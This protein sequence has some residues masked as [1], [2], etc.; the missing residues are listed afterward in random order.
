MTSKKGVEL[1]PTNMWS[2]HFVG[3]VYFFQG[4]YEKA[5]GMFESVN[6]KLKP[7]FRISLVAQTHFYLGQIEGAVNMLE[8]GLKEYPDEPQLNST[9]AI[10]LASKG[11][12]GE[13]RSKMAVAIE[14]R[15]ELRHVHHLYHNLAAVTALMGE[16]K[17]AVEWLIKAADDGFPSYPLFKRD[18]NLR[19]LRGSTGYEEFMVEMKEKLLHFDSL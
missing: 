9:Y 10:I 17:E 8:E 1:E 7:Y 11:K 18:P 4:E 14:N 16:N 13:A 5:L 6:V 3:Q 15:S 12:N 2:R 19:N